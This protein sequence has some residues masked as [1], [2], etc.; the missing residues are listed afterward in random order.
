MFDQITSM[1]VLG[2][3]ILAGLVVLVGG[4]IAAAVGFFRNRTE[5]Q[6]QERIERWRADPQ[7]M[8]RAIAAIHQEDRAR[9]VGKRDLIQTQ[10]AQ[11]G[12]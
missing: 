4:A 5:T 12:G 9:L 8:A 1:G 3:A 11:N 10:P 7:G 6:R 2:W